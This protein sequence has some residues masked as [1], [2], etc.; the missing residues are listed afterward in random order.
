M[1]LL[2]LHLV[3]ALLN[4]PLVPDGADFLACSLDERRLSCEAVSCGGADEFPCQADGSLPLPLCR[5][6]GKPVP[7]HEEKDHEC[8]VNSSCVMLTCNVST[9]KCCRDDNPGDGQSCNP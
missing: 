4:P 5:P 1:N 3:A 8:C 2:P 9:N 7:P 6:L